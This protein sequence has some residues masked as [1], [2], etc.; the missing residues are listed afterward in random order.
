MLQHGRR[1]LARSLPARVV[2]SAGAASHLRDPVRALPFA[3]SDSIAT[4]AA[5]SAACCCC[6]FFSST[7]SAAAT[8]EQYEEL[9]LPAAAARV[10]S[11]SAE[12]ALARANAAANGASSPHV[13][14]V[15][16]DRA[17]VAARLIEYAH[18][19]QLESAEAP[20]ATLAPRD[21]SAFVFTG[22]ISNYEKLGLWQQAEAAWARLPELHVEPTSSTFAALIRVYLHAAAR[23]EQAQLEKV[24]PLYATMRRSRG[25]RTP[26]PR[27]ETASLSLRERTLLRFTSRDY[28]RI[29]KTAH[30]LRK[31]LGEQELQ[32]W[33]QRLRES[34]RPA[35]RETRRHSE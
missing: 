5:P 22:W 2:R 18:Q 20:V 15:R 25:L 24:E 26:A 32:K 12:E 7:S 9:P 35:G 16:G 17:T 11:L 27:G 29:V 21:W 1:S 30:R 6:R 34:G 23:G 19:N 33:A 3:W 14:E 4:R 31:A 13:A 8:V 28:D 10:T